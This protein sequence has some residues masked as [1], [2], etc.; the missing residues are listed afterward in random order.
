M[1]DEEFRFTCKNNHTWLASN[2]IRAFCPEC[3]SSTRR[4][5][6]E[7]APQ[8]TAK[9]GIKV[10]RPIPETTTQEEPNSVPTRTTKTTKKPASKA[11]PPRTP[12]R[13]PQ[14]KPAQAKTAPPPASHS[15]LQR[16]TTSRTA[17][18][19]VSTKKKLTT[20]QTNTTKEAETMATRMRR[21]A[22]GR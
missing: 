17:A 14:A 2:K 15:V 16:R 5:P 9:P 21:L 6:Q 13:K 4:T 22:F 8:T 20:K 7:T 12:A 11:T 18:P 10:V 1:A 3:G 19:I